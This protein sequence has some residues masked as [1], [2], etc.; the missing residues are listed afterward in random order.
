MPQRFLRPG[1]TNSDAWNSISFPAQSMYIRILTLVDDYG[2][3]DGRI[4]ILHAHCFALRSDITPQDSAA[5]VRE[6][7]ESGLIS[8]YSVDGKPFLQL[9]KWEER[10]RGASKYPSPDEGEELDTQDS[11][12]ERSG[13]QPN[14]AS[15]A[16]SPSHRPSPSSIA[17][18]PASRTL[19]HFLNERTGRH[20]R[21]VETNLKVIH[22][23]LQEPGVDLEGCK[24]MIERQVKKWKGTAMEEY[25]RPMTLFGK[26]KFD[27]Y[28][29]AKDMPIAQDR[30]T[31]TQPQRSLG[32]IPDA[33]GE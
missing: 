1:I 31:V 10:A 14:P 8:L 13:T 32:Y 23:R 18:C 4:A 17:Y 22:A 28:Y 33:T 19:L 26:E 29:S 21:E 11:A 7:Q 12:A 20:L 15:L 3:Y 25:L 5:F 16:L 6:M 30:E 2:R 27:G 9:S 24:A